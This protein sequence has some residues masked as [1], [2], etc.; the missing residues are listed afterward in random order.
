MAEE[1]GYSEYN[2]F[3][4]FQNI[5]SIEGKI[6][7]HLIKSTSKHARNFWKI[8]KYDDIYALSQPD[9]KEEERR[10]LVNNDNGESTTK[11]VFFSPFVDDAWEVQCSS[12]YIFVEYIQPLDH[13]RSVI[14]VTIETIVHSKISAIS[15]DGDPILN[16][17]DVT[18]ETYGAN[19]NDSDSQDSIV[20][21][22][23]NRATVLLKSVLAE[24]NGLYLDGIG[25]LQIN[26]ESGL[27]G[28]VTMPLFNNRS[29]YG[30][31]ARFEIA[32]SGISDSANIG[33]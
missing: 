29:F 30:H 32:L 18:N 2:S 3:N 19:P 1:W 27:N 16:P 5:D 33:F 25:Y 22:Y 6:V 8:L 21:P 9:V 10:A 31:A 26:R 24:L 17:T 12:V 14:G 4:R 28:K 20:V 23:K 11:R 13:L 7:E 15:G